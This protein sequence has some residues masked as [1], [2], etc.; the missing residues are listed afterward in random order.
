MESTRSGPLP[1]LAPATSFLCPSYQYF[2]LILLQSPHT[3]FPSPDPGNGLDRSSIS[4]IAA[5]VL[6]EEKMA[7]REHADRI[8]NFSSVDW[9]RRG[10]SSSF[11]REGDQ[12]Y[13]EI[14][15]V[16]SVH[17]A[18]PTTTEMIHQCVCQW[19]TPCT[20]GRIICHIRPD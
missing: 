11:A 4:G 19:A 7:Y 2:S 9:Q 3:R 8:R 16:F 14:S 6:L 1:R 15:T 20:Y 17:S 10:G 5:I 12:Y 18:G 13:W